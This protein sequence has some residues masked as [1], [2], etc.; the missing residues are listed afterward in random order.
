MNQGTVNIDL[1]LENMSNQIANLSKEKAVVQAFSTQQAQEI[2]QL[3]AEI[4]QLKHFIEK[5]D[6]SKAD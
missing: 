1:V 5:N 3:R 2:E 6:E 4:E